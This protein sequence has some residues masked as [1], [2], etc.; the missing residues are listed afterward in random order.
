[1]T[2]HKKIKTI[3]K[4]TEYDIH[5]KYLCPECGQSHWLSW[6]ETSIKNFKT[7]CDCGCVFKVKRTKKFNIVYKSK[8]RKIDNPATNPIHNHQIIERAIK[9]LSQYG[10]TTEELKP[11]VEK[12]FAKNPC[13]D[14]SSL[15]K[16]T[17][18]EL[19][20]C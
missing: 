13:I 3:K 14:I 17:L 16:E 12:C 15:V 1:M 8:K 9:T 11:V 19:K 5:L 18:I 20:G 6:K 7:V 2:T 4:P 10:F